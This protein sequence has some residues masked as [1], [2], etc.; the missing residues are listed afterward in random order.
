MAQLFGRQWSRAE[1][2]AHVGDLSQL[3]GV[4]LGEW[5]EGTERGVRTADVRTGS[6]FEFTV[7]LDRGMDIGPALYRGLPLGWISPAG[8]SHPA[9]YDPVGLGWLRTFGGGLLT[10]C[11]LTYLGAPG[12]DEGEALGLH[13]R[14][15]HLPARHVRV[16]EDWQGD[17]C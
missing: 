3:A 7:L 6:G 13:G 2:L 5:S 8:F 1:L 15:S 9:Y 14:L 12:V 16:G 11:G 17:E 10:G 4:R